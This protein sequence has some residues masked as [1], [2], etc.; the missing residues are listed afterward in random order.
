MLSFQ[1]SPKRY[2][3]WA[4]TAIACAASVAQAQT[5]DD[6]VIEAKRAYFAG[7]LQTAREISS[8]LLHTSKTQEDRRLAYDSLDTI[9]RINPFSF[10]VSGAIMPST[11]VN[12]APYART[13]ST[14][15]G[16][17]TIDDGGQEQT[18]IGYQLG[19]NMAYR[20]VVGPGLRLNSAVGLTRVQYPNYDTRNEWI[21]TPSI[22]LVKELPGYTISGGI[23]LRHARN[24]NGTYRDD[25]TVELTGT[26]VMSASLT[27]TIAAKRTLTDHSSNDY[28]DGHT[29]T[30][31]FGMNRAVSDTTN[32]STTFGISES[33]LTQPHISHKSGHIFAG[34]DHRVGQ[35]DLVSISLRAEKRDYSGRV[36]LVG[37]ARQDDI[38]ELGLGWT[39]KRVRLFGSAPR[40]SCT[41]KHTASNVALYGTRSTDCSLS[42]SRQ[43]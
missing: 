34:V 1:F 15:A 37:Y 8:A 2:L 19:V 20:G 22:R 5:R 29:D 32:L 17:F 35:F 12:S 42:L 41:Y 18:G 33:K 40:L 23:R 38:Y 25:L 13:L 6:Y 24:D 14:N 16:T 3:T 36:P 10:G 9:D 21:A 28:S 26:R 11:N 31:T 7:D 43:F 30:I 4:L 39:N 27:Y